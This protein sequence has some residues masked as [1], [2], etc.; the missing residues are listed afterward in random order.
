MVKKCVLLG[1]HRILILPDIRPAGILATVVSLPIAN[2]FLAKKTSLHFSQN[3]Y[4]F[5]LHKKQH[6][7]FAFSSVRKFLAS[8]YKDL[9]AYFTGYPVSDRIPDMESRISA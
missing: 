4:F 9:T 1:M 3:S 2:H 8:V 5:F 7:T 6:K